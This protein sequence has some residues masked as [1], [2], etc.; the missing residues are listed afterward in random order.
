MAITLKEGDKAPTFEAKDQNEKTIKL[1]DFE[2]KKLILFFYPKDNTPGCTKEACNLRDN[3]EY[4]INQGYAVLGVSPDGAASHQKFIEKFDL[5]FPLLADIKKEVMA[6]YGTW[7]EKNMY[8][9]IRM[10]VLRTTFIIDEEGTIIKIFKRPKT[11]A[12][13]EQISKAL[14][15]PMV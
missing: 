5:P 14:D 15:L 2:G 4:W 12:H 10:G 7:G 11:A 6:A 1:T 13:T 9:K 3:H 8:G